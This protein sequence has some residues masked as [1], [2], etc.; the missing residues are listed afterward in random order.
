MKSKICAAGFCCVLALTVVNS[1]AD[2]HG[3]KG[4]IGVSSAKRTA[5]K[6][7][8]R[9]SVT[10]LKDGHGANEAT[11]TATMRNAR[12]QNIGAPVKAKKVADG[13]YEVT[14]TAPKGPWTLRLASLRPPASLE[15][16]GDDQTGR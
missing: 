14:V 11:L 2:A 9:L 10:F 3:G 12:Q 15:V 4:K 16:K 6:L 13:V 5:D 7:T 1:P 8:Y